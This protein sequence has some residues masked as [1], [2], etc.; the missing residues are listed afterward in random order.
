[1]NPI[2]ASCRVTLFSSIILTATAAAQISNTTATLEGTIADTIGAVIQS[3]EVKL[4]NTANNQT[5]TVQADEQGFF[6]ASGLPVG[7]Y[8][9]RVEQPGFVPYVHTGITLTVGQTV[10]FNIELAPGGATAQVTVTGQPPAIEPADRSVRWSAVAP[11]PVDRKTP[12]PRS[13]ANRGL[14]RAGSASR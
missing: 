8:E 11:G 3:A 1:M 2:L 13:D 14:R 7:T 4:R 12:D 5:R 9:V 10:R 6:R